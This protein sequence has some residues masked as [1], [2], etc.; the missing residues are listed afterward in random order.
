MDVVG[1]VAEVFVAAVFACFCPKEVDTA[2]LTRRGTAASGKDRNVPVSRY[3]RFLL[4]ENTS[5][6]EKEMIKYLVLLERM[7]KYYQT[8]ASQAIE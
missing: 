1:A 4:K 6:Q 5:R 7:R 8:L 2:R 3:H